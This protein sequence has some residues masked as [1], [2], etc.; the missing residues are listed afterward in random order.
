MEISYEISGAE[1]NQK[2]TVDLFVS[3]DGGI[4]YKGPMT[5]LSSGNTEIIEGVN[6]LVWDI[7]KDINSLEQ[8]LF[9]DIRATVIE[10]EIEKL[11]FIQYSAGALVSSMNYVT[12]F[13][14]RIGRV[15]KIGWYAAGYFNTFATTD[16]NYDGESMEGNIFYEFTDETLYPR[17][18]ILAGITYQVG[19]NA[20]LFAG[21]G[22]AT[23]KYYMQINEF[24]AN[25]S[26]KNAEQW[27]NVT[28]HDEAGVEIEAGSIFNFNKLSVS[29]GL[30]TFNF[31]H[32]G[33]NAGVGVA[34]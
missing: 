13:G 29:L 27:V 16:Y 12:P 3:T 5:I 14:F 30:S 4:T 9:F 17:M 22:F 31:K 19:R 33:I 21:A 7:F 26:I 11:Y 8:E 1:F 15:G 34:F 24:N 23:K 10:E 25:G 2:F 6:K 20:Y 32:L 28:T 18:A